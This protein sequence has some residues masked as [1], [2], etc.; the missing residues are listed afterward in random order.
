M[1]ENGFSEL[2][3]HY[4]AVGKQ[5]GGLPIQTPWPLVRKRTYTNLTVDEI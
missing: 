2:S 4:R 1:G 3:T 5:G